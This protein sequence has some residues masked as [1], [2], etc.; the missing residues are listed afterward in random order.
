[1]TVEDESDTEGAEQGLTAQEK[2]ENFR[3]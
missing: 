3:V 1:L 2:A